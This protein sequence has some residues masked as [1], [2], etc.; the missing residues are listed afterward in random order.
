M[1]VAQYSKPWLWLDM[2]NN[3]LTI[4]QDHK[5]SA[6]MGK[7]VEANM[8]TLVALSHQKLGDK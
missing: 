8:G 1:K 2:V 3:A 5:S 6:L 7:T 4:V